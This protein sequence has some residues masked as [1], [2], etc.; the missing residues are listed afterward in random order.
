MWVGGN[1]GALLEAAKKRLEPTGRIIVQVEINGQALIGA[2]LAKHRDDPITN[3][4]VSLASADP[5]ELALSTLEQLQAYLKD[6]GE[7]LHQAGEMF[8]TD[9]GAQAMRELGKAMDV[10]HQLPQALIQAATL[11]KVNLDSLLTPPSTMT[12]LT[13]DLA[14]K[15]RMLHEHL[16]NGDLVALADA[17]TYEWPMLVATWDQL[18]VNFVKKLR[19]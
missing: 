13:S 17:L 2:E 3:A 19:G 8:Q 10:W 5:R 9:R 6:A 4:T 7:N 11:T 18:I 14:D 16:K 1:L 15:L 12:A